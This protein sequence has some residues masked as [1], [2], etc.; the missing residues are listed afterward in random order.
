MLLSLLSFVVPRPSCLVL[1]CSGCVVIMVVVILIL[2]IFIGAG[3]GATAGVEM[4]GDHDESVVQQSSSFHI[5][6][7]HGNNLGSEKC[8]GWNWVNYFCV[9]QIFVSS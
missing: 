9:G 7:V 4:S 5:L 8:N 6:E 3:A 2:S 1:S